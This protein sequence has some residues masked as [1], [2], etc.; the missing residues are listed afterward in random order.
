MAKFLV[1]VFLGIFTGL[2]AAGLSTADE[3]LITAKLS[4]I[5]SLQDNGLPFSGWQTFG[6][7]LAW[8][9]PL[10]VAACCLVSF[11]VPP[12]LRPNIRQI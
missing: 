11:D 9:I 6:F 3:K 7:H 2:L 4:L 10:L 5:E 8:S 12:R 1:V